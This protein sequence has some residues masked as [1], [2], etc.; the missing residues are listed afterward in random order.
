MEYSVGFLISYQKR[1]D[2]IA[3][4]PMNREDA[5]RYLKDMR[6]MWPD[7]VMLHRSPGQEEWE[8]VKS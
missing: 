1:G 2:W 8:Q 4:R 3:A 6:A 7:A 5:Q